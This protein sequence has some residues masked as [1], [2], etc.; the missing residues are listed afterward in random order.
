MGACF[1]IVGLAASL[2]T[3]ACSSSSGVFQVAPDTYQITTTAITSFGGP[4]HRARR[5]YQERQRV[6][7]QDGQ[8]TDD[9][10]RFDQRAVH[11]G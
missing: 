9:P 8:V 5:C 3:V 4:G 7:C 2:A 11:P 1:R 10:R 6:L